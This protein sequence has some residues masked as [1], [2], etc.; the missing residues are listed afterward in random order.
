MNLDMFIRV[1]L[2][3]LSNKYELSLVEI[4]KVKDG[5]FRKTYNF[6]YRPHESRPK[7]NICNTFY[8]KRELVSW[9]ACLN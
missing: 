6:N 5:K 1:K 4:S 3:S 9:L 2:L 7:D 8:N